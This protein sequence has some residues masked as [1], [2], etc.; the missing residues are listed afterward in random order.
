MLA[1][2]Q[3]ARR[4]QRIDERNRYFEHVRVPRGGVGRAFRARSRGWLKACLMR[5]THFPPSRRLFKPLLIVPRPA[6]DTTRDCGRPG[7]PPQEVWRPPSLKFSRKSLFLHSGA[8]PTLLGSCTCTSA[9]EGS[10][11]PS[12]DSLDQVVCPLSF[13][14]SPTSDSLVC[15]LRSYRLASPPNFHRRGVHFSTPITQGL[16]ICNDRNTATSERGLL[17]FKEKRG[18]CA[19]LS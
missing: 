8:L 9:S 14:S 16:I 2:S 5:Q 4:S 17:D 3:R 6:R 13:Y 11:L 7:D 1:M 10:S 19:A 15:Y 12:P 18:I